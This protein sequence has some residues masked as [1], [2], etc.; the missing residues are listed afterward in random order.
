MKIQMSDLDFNAVPLQEGKI[1]IRQSN[2]RLCEP[3][4]TQTGFF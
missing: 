1:N 4:E 2:A 3:N